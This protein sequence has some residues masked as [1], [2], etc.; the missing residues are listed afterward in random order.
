MVAHEVPFAGNSSLLFNWRNIDNFFTAYELKTIS[1]F[2]TFWKTRS[3]TLS[4]DDYRKIVSIGLQRKGKTVT[5]NEVEDLI[6]E[7]MEDKSVMDLLLLLQTAQLSALVNTDE[8][9][10][11]TGEPA[12][13]KPPKHSK[14]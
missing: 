11:P 14:N 4:F 5:P 3:D 10:E 2:D 9:G 7:Y 8:P 13:V 6:E 12:K 1:D